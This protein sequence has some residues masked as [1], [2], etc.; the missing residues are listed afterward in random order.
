MNS[1]INNINKLNL[2]PTSFEFDGHVF[3]EDTYGILK[4]LRYLIKKLNKI[5]LEKNKKL[6]V[7]DIG[8]GTGINI[9]IPLA[10]AGYAIKGIDIDKKSIEKARDLSRG[11]PNITFLCM[12]IQ[13]LSD[14]DIYDVIICSEV[15]E[16][17][18]NPGEF[19]KSIYS[20]LDDNGTLIITI[21]NGYGYFELES[22]IEKKFPNLTY[23]LDGLIQQLFKDYSKYLP[24]AL[25]KRHRSERTREYCDLSI[26]TFDTV[27]KHCN[28]FA[29]RTLVR[30]L[31]DNNFRIEE[32]KNRTFLAGNIINIL[33]R[34]WDVLLRMNS[35]V[36]D[37]LPTWLCSGWMV[38]AKKKI[39]AQISP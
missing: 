5:S 24:D 3:R 22:F 31:T 11:I 17:I 18:P 20:I 38:A 33:L 23:R 27:T 30:L 16:H 28:K 21:P 32:I 10:L 36:A 37:Y 13:Q 2:T 26:T 7:L 6:N 34:E 15:L 35:V 39:P 12:E 25:N 8:C 4:R 9:T 29:K 19:I 14:N 1:S